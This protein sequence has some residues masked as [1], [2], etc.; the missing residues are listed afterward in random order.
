M[1]GAIMSLLSRGGKGEGD[2]KAG[3]GSGTGGP[4][5]KALSAAAGSRALALAVGAAVD[6]AYGRGVV[7][8]V[9]PQ[10][11]GTLVV[12]LD[13]GATAYLAQVRE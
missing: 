9:R 4:K 12:A 2:D 13:W 10:G 7:K 5:A 8:Q 11:P 1:A 6:T 3:A